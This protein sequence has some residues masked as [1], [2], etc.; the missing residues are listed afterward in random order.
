M[1]A[2][3]I[4]L[5]G[6]VGAVMHVART[7][8]DV[9]EIDV[10]YAQIRRAVNLLRAAGE[11]RTLDALLAACE[12]FDVRVRA[13]WEIRLRAAEVLRRHGNNVFQI[14]E[15]AKNARRCIE[16]H[17]ETLSVYRLRISNASGDYGSDL[18]GAEE[19]VRKY[20]RLAEEEESE[21]RFW[22]RRLE[23][24]DE[25][26]TGVNRRC[27]KEILEYADA[28][29]RVTNDAG[30]EPSLMALAQHTYETAMESPAIRR[31]HPLFSGLEERIRQ[32]ESEGNVSG[33]PPEQV[34]EWWESL[35]QEERDTLISEAPYVV[36]NF[37][38]IPLRDR[39]L[40]NAVLA[41]L[42]AKDPEAGDEERAYW[43]SVADGTRKL[44]VLDPEHDRIVE[45]IGDFGPETEHVFTYLPGTGACLEDFYAGNKQPLAKSL[46]EQ[47]HGS[48]VAFVYKDGPWMQWSGD[49][50]NIS[51]A[52][53]T[54][55][56][57]RL[58]GFQRSTL[59]LEPELRDAKH[60]VGGHSAGLTPIS[61]SEVAGVEYDTVLSI[62]GSWLDDAWK[63]NPGTEYHHFQYRE[64]ILNMLEYGS[65]Q[66]PHRGAHDGSSPFTL[67]EFKNVDGEDS[68]AAHERIAQGPDTN[69]EPLGKMYEALK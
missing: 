21:V 28:L 65:K 37:V 30:G 27:A 13:I 66:Y 14:Q 9:D 5:R 64:D 44:V 15:D 61:S 41:G 45:M 36:G 42:Y 34:R 51:D 25:A 40:A 7:L 49:R 56:G 22:E 48:L 26:R 69:E 1:T 6:E 4:A 57:K 33:L 60:H 31:N 63:P 3:D 19:A 46:V 24:L 58:A 62:S 39:V 55:L 29:N 53:S 47:S 16:N 38:G 50:S 67:H 8:A 23:N 11:S 54:K 32:W 20:T 18:Q 17:Q 52:F 12:A 2:G 59:D 35:T 10:A 68:F 43:T